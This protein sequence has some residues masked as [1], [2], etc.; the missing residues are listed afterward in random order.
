M[1]KALYHALEE[2][3]RIIRYYPVIKQV[4]LVHSELLIRFRDLSALILLLLLVLFNL[5][6][7]TVK[8]L[9]VVVRKLE[10]VEGILR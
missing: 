4:V 7:D 8:N 9:S 6:Y 2:L 3:L 5:G 10:I 1:L